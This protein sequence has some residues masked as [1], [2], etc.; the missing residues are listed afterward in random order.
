MWLLITLLTLDMYKNQNALIHDSHC[1]NLNLKACCLASNFCKIKLNDL[2]FRQS[3]RHTIIQNILLYIGLNYA[4]NLKSHFNLWD[5]HLS[6]SCF[7]S[8]CRRERP[9]LSFSVNLRISLSFFFLCRSYLMSSLDFSIWTLRLNN[10]S[11]KIIF[12]F[13]FSIF[14]SSTL[15]D[16]SFSFKSVTLDSKSF[17]LSFNLEF[18]LS[19]SCLRF[20]TFSSVLCK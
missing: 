13:S 1:P 4:C 17:S 8:N 6:I 11:S 7:S 14:F 15:R 3:I 18:F 9:N 12:S 20:E 16:F 2:I 19:R 5:L 10:F